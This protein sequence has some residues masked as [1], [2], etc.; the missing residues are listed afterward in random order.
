MGMNYATAQAASASSGT[1]P[2]YVT[3]NAGIPPA[4]CNIPFNP[5]TMVINLRDA[6]VLGKDAQGDYVETNEI[7]NLVQQANE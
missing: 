4:S 2:N 7:V 3:G 5:F 6:K 1:N